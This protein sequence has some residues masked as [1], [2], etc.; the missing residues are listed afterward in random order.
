MSLGQPAVVSHYAGIFV[1]TQVRLESFFG[2][3][4]STYFELYYPTWG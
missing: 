2:V 4:H 3:V 1:R